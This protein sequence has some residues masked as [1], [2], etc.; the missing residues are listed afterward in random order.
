MKFYFP[1]LI[2]LSV[3]SITNAQDCG[4]KRWDVKTLSDFDTTYINFNNIINS[5]V[6]Q[7]C[8]L[9]KPVGKNTFRMRS[10]DTVYSITCYILAYKKQADDK[11]IHIVIQDPKTKEM[12][13]AELISS[14]CMSVKKTSRYLQMKNLGEWFIEN[15]GMPQEKFTYLHK[16]KLVTITGVGFFDTEHGQKGMAE[17]GREIHPI[18]TMKIEPLSKKHH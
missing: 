4:S 8:H 3:V 15:I 10:E 18:L 2:L 14:D 12:M 13:V 9:P 5:S 6:H 1:L 7:Q 11:D 17:N 16:P